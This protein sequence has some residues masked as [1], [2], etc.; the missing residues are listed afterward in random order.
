MKDDALRHREW[1]QCPSCRRSLSGFPPE[2][3]ACPGCGFAIRL[4]D[5]G[6]WEFGEAYF[7]DYWAG[8]P[9]KRAEF[10]RKWAPLDAERNLRFT[11][12]QALP[13]LRSLFGD[14]AGVRVLSSGC[15]LGVDVEFLRE[16]GYDAWGNDIG[17]RFLFWKDRRCAAFLVKC[18]SEEMPFPDHSFDFVQSHLV[19]EHVG[20]VGDSIRARPDY[21]EIRKRFLH[22]LFRVV[23][24][25]GYLQ[26]ST[27][28]RLFPVD[29]G[30]AVGSRLGVRFHGPGDRFLTSYGDM[31]RYFP[32]QEILPVS[33]ATYYAGTC[34][35]RFGP[36]KYA[37]QAYLFAM[38]K[39]PFL[40][41]TALN[42]L[43]NTLV[44]KSEA[45]KS[46]IL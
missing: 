45:W 39:L 44:R 18:A 40:R 21:W 23:K 9:E 2:A 22:S 43:M 15:G 8:D 46:D 31:A 30:H 35:R 11:R 33:P 32:G 26:V 20:V 42:P 4:R 7:P 25:G 19:L 36:L 5:E 17:S 1:F 12:D 14:R 29:P 16:Q 13:I 41:G 28:N 24:P 3:R 27:P 10:E 6:F 38:D 37:F 34:V